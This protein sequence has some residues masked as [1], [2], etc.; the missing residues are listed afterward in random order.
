MCLQVFLL[1]ALLFHEIMTI[2]WDA[3]KQKQKKNGNCAPNYRYLKSII[4]CCVMANIHYMIIYHNI[5][6]YYKLNLLNDFRPRSQLS[7][8]RKT[9]HS[10]DSLWRRM[11]QATQS[12]ELSGLKQAV[13]TKYMEQARQ[14]ARYH[15]FTFYLFS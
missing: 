11:R 2:L 1:Y 5:G 13:I 6:Q 4:K 10:L 15:H 14:Q 3:S 7:G 9:H 8:C 12:L